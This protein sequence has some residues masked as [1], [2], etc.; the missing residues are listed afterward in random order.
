[1]DIGAVNIGD[2]RLIQSLLPGTKSLWLRNKDGEVMHITE[3]R[4]ALYLDLLFQLE[5]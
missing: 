5:F 3:S 4:F 1:M 2:Y